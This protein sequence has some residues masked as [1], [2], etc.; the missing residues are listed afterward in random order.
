MKAKIVK[1]MVVSSHHSHILG[2]VSYLAVPAATAS[3]SAVVILSR[4]LTLSL[5]LYLHRLDLI[6]AWQHILVVLCSLMWL[7]NSF[8][9]STLT[10]FHSLVLD[11]CSGLLSQSLVSSCFSL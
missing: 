4:K 1:L 9:A 6:Q 10:V 5:H 3:F 7:S 8:Q 2:P 11:P